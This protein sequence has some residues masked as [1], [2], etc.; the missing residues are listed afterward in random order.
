MSVRLRSA[1]LLLLCA[2]LAA[3]APAANAAWGDV[4]YDVNPALI[5]LDKSAQFDAFGLLTGLS[6]AAGGAR[7]ARQDFEQGFAA[8]Q[9]LSD[10]VALG[11]GR[12]RFGFGDSLSS[13][14]WR[15]RVAQIDPNATHYGLAHPHATYG[16]VAGVDN[17]PRNYVADHYFLTADG[18][19]VPQYFV[20]QFEQP[21]V[22]VGLS[23]IDFGNGVGGSSELTMLTGSDL[24]TAVALPPG[25]NVGT[26][27]SIPAGE[28]DGSFDYFV[29]HGASSPQFPHQRPSFDFVVLR[30]DTIDPAFGF[31]NLIVAR[32]ALPASGSL[33][34]LLSG[35]GLLGAVRWRTRSSVTCR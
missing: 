11:D 28:I 1:F 6:A 14:A 35:L 30:F 32:Q 24:A 18:T 2:G 10:W 34:L 19:G 8:A 26:R 23:M 15:S 17:Q 16:N 22:F 4:G 3:V 21:V 27:R 12:V 25:N 5:D 13:I 9:I 7:P 33:P 20:M 31:D 29:A